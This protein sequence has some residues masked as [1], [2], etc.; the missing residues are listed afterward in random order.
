MPCLNLSAYPASHRLHVSGQCQLPGHFYPHTSSP[1]R[2]PSSWHP[3]SLL[4]P[5]PFYPFSW[6]PEG[7]L[8]HL[9][10]RH[11]HLPTFHLPQLPLAQGHG[12]CLLHPAGTATQSH[13]L[14]CLYALYLLFPLPGILFY[15]TISLAN[16]YFFSKTQVTSSR[17]SSLTSP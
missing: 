13:V 15:A 6:Q 9:Q 8:S 3:S 12:Q 17:K 10:A 16:C 7:I 11:N 4:S 1:L 14:S 5:S 2:L